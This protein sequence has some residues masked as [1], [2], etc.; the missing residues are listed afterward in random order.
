MLLFFSL[1]ASISFTIP[2]NTTVLLDHMTLNILFDLAS[3][4]SQKYRSIR[5]QEINETW[6]R[7]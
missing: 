7:G 2:S 3:L 1:S 6:V 4:L 5:H